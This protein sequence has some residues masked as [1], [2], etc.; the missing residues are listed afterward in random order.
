MAPK[1]AVPAGKQWPEVM[2]LNA[3]VTWNTL[4]FVQE[5]ADFWFKGDEKKI[6]W[7]RQNPL[8]A[9]EDIFFSFAE[10]AL[11]VDGKFPTCLSWQ[12]LVFLVKAYAD[13]CLYLAPTES[14]GAEGSVQFPS[15]FQ[16]SSY[17]QR[18][19]V[20]KCQL[21]F[22]LQ[23]WQQNYTAK[24][25]K[26][27]SNSFTYPTRDFTVN[28]ERSWKVDLQCPLPERRQL[29]GRNKLPLFQ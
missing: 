21:Q 13:V 4:D 22:S 12:A 10:I 8:F 24:K 6:E 29:R 19:G 17:C 2:Q 1:A 5:N 7:F 23:E 16:Q 15:P 27:N 18:G 14:C 26:Y 20:E 3:D 9:P 28:A 25:I 11:S